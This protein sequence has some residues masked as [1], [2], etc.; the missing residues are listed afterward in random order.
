M[1]VVDVDNEASLLPERIGM[2]RV[3]A[4]EAHDRPHVLFAARR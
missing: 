3:E 2:S 4:I 1:A